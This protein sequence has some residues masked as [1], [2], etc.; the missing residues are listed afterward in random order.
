M[1]EVNTFQI[2]KTIDFTGFLW[3]FYDASEMFFFSY[4]KS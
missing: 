2:R 4:L 3:T 1:D